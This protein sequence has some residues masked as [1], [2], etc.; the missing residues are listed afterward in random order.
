MVTR[1]TATLGYGDA[2]QR[3]AMDVVATLDALTVDGEPILSAYRAEQDGPWLLDI[4][5]TDTDAGRR[6]RWL[7]IARELLPGLPEFAEDPLAERDWV[8]ESQRALHPVRAGRFVVFGSHDKARMPASRWG[9]LIDAERAFGTAHH[10]TTQGCL[11]ALERLARRV[12]LGTV[13]DVGTGTGVLGI[14]AARL[15]ARRVMASDI[16]PVAVTI[17]RQNIR[18]NHA[19][20]VR[21]LGASGPLVEADVVIANILARPLIAMASRL[22]RSARNWLI[23]SGLRTADVRRI[24]AAYRARG[25]AIRERLVIEDWATL[26]F[27]RREGFVRRT[28]GE[29]LARPYRPFASGFDGE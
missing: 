1:A 16:D 10:A 25:F 7:S 6:T 12:P 17:A 22:A 13:A 4:L 15:G 18:A 27:E 14:A 3:R 5:F 24:R 20:G 28:A 2:L 8:A 19:R 23:L 11:I 9:L 21:A 26:T 29:R